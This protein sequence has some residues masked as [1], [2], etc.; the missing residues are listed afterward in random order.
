MALI[1]LS[2]TRSDSRDRPVSAA[3]SA[4]LLSGEP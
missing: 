4:I 3:A 1:R 2:V